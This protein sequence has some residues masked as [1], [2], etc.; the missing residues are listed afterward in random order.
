MT[1]FHGMSL[2]T[3]KLRSM[4]KKWQTLIEG[5]VDAKVLKVP[6]VYPDCWRKYPPCFVY[7]YPTSFRLLMDIPSLYSVFISYIQ[8][9]DGYTLRVF[10]IYILYSDYW[11]IYPPCILY[12]YPIFRLL[13]DIPSVNSVF[14]S[15]YIQQCFGSISFWFGSGSAD[16][17]PWWWIRILTLIRIRVRGNFWFCESD[18]PY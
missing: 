15:N 18:F 6:S 2:T 7:L 10:C 14:I 3:D 16:P 11:W 1:N 12:L 5:N 9:T 17:H 13:M 4:V 8:T